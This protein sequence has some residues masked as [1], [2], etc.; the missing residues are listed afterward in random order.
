MEILGVRGSFRADFNPAFGLLVIPLVFLA[1]LNALGA[2]F[3]VV[4]FSV[5]QIG[6]ESAARKADVSS[7]ILLV[8]VGLMLLFMAVTEYLRARRSARPRFVTPGLAET[9]AAPAPGQADET[10]PVQPGVS[11][12]LGPMERPAQQRVPH[13]ARR[14][15]PARRDA[16]AVREPRRDRSRSRPACS[17]SG[18]RA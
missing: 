2:L 5:I 13:G 6:G 15:R 7:D 4:G 18:S 16:A 17:T 12:R 8:L 3:F 1:R 9:R 10:R 11:A 14:R